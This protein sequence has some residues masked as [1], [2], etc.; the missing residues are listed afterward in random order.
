MVHGVLHAIPFF[1]IVFLF[2]WE[3]A[4]AEVRFIPQVSLGQEYTNNLF[5]DDTDSEK[6]HDATTMISPGFGFAART[7]RLDSSLLSRAIFLKYR[8]SDDLD[9]TDQEHLARL[10]YRLTE[11]WKALA[12]AGF[13]RNSRPDRDITVTGL[14]LNA[15]RRDRGHLNMSTEYALS[16]QTTAGEHPLLPWKPVDP[17]ARR[18][19]QRDAICHK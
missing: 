15:E 5:F 12:E 10:A 8:E 16:E 13:T 1:L 11:R 7:E 3:C 9:T 2:P 4:G 6:V 14:I 19:R 17:V 18:P